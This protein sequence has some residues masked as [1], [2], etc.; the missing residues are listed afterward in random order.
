VP[1]KPGLGWHREINL[2]TGYYE[3]ERDSKG[4]LTKVT[5][6][7]MEPGE[8]YSLGV[9][10]ILGKGC[11]LAKVTFIGE[12]EDD[13]EFWQRLFLVRVPNASDVSAVINQPKVATGRNASQEAAGRAGPSNT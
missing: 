5:D 8:S 11:Y 9:P 12:A 6:F 2:A 13:S 7:W 3:V 1:Q 4:L 10:L